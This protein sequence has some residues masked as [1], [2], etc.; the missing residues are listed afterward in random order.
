MKKEALVK[1]SRFKKFFIIL[2]CKIRT[3]TLWQRLVGWLCVLVWRR[4]SLKE[5]KSCE[6]HCARWLKGRFFSSAT[7]GMVTTKIFSHIPLTQQLLRVLLDL[8]FVCTLDWN[9]ELQIQT[10]L[11]H[12]WPEEDTEQIKVVLTF[13]LRELHG[14]V[15]KTWYNERTKKGKGSEDCGTGY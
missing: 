14:L 13:S 15:H 11:H 3:C 8:L 7:M 4:W 6:G 9:P 1:Q 10:Q 2:L 5:S 12:S